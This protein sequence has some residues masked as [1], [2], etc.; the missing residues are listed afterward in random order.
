MMKKISLIT[1]LVLAVLSGSLLS[2]FA[3]AEEYY[4]LDSSAEV[5]QQSQAF[6]DAA[7]INTE[8]VGIGAIVAVVIKILLSFLGVIFVILTI[9]AGYL[10]MTSAGNEEKISKAKKIMAAAVI[11]LTIVISAYGITIFVIDKILGVSGVSGGSR[12]TFEGSGASRTERE[13]W[14]WWKTYTQ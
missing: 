9:Y 13:S 7:G 12:G 2:D 1:L 6:A 4:P 5:E 8:P 14:N 10:W 11:G 3:Y